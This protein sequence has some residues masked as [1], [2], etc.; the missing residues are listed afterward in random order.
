MKR[1]PPPGRRL[2]L[3]A[4]LLIAVFSIAPV[5]AQ[6]PS[7]DQAQSI[8]SEGAQARPASPG[9]PPEIADNVA[10]LTA[11]IETAEKTIQHLAELEEEL[12]GLRV[13]VETIIDDSSQIAEVL[14]PQLAAVRSQIDKLGPSPGKDGPAE[15]PALAAERARLTAFAAGLDGAIKSS[16]LTWVRARQLIEKIT[17][18]RH[19]LFAK[20]LME[21][22]PSPLL[23]DV[24]RDLM[25]KAP[26]VGNRISYLTDD[27]LRWAS[28]K[29]LKLGLL[30]SAVVILF[31]ALRVGLGRLTD[32]RQRPSEPPSFFERAMSVA[33]VAPL[34]ALPT[35]AAALLLYAG[36]DAMDLLFPPWGVTAAG[37]L[38]AVVLYAAV[39]AL[40]FA[41]LAPRTPQWRLFSLADGP[42]RRVGA[43]L[44]AITA[45]YA[46]DGALTEIS[47]V[48]F[49]P[50]ALTV[51][52]TF[53]TSIAFAALLIGLLLTPF[54]PQPTETAGAAEVAT[55]SASAAERYPRQAP[56]WLKLPLWLIALAILGLAL[57]GYVALARFVAQQLVLTGIVLVVSW[58]L[59]LAI[60][61]V[62]REPQQRRYPVGELLE[63]RFGLDAPRR[64]QLA[65]L[66]EIALTFAL[67][68]CAL[69]FLMMQW[70]FSGADIRDWFKS[71]FFGIEV[72]QFRISLARILIGIVLFIVLLF[73]TRLLQRWLREK[74]LQQTRMDPGIANSVDTV[75]GYVGVSLAALLAVSYAGV[76]ITNLAIVAGALSVGIGFGLQSIVNNFV[77]GLILLIERPIKVGDRI[78]VGDQQGLVRRISVR[79]TEIETFDR[80]SL[81]VPNSEL[82]TGRV[83]NWTHRDSLGAV[84]VKVGVGYDSD[85]EQVLAILKKCAD[86]HPDVLRTPAPMAFFDNFGDSALMFTLRIS[87]PDIAQAAR[88]QS[89][90][91]TAILK[92]LRAAEIEIP[93]NQLDVNLRQLDGVKRYHASHVQER[94]DNG[95]QPVEPETVGANNGKRLAGVAE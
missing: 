21:R 74:A 37:V 63:A 30:L 86:D 69:P 8:P 45:L 80:A 39:S 7:P 57:L 20:N 34:R 88:V 50:L 48:F 42:T 23:P 31:V 83:L 32:R 67:V 29:Q 61:A 13:D 91:R 94:A 28:I 4:A 87:L 84:N 18:L 85:P 9:L 26:P 82:I 1:T 71:L 35:I 65:R 41:M 27:W 54:I 90:L 16:E 77:S 79:A 60:R 93:F 33:W 12:G 70:G 78:V 73:A 43:L 14:R 25:S 17:V 5:A 15:A 62:T 72:G 64:N 66:T 56:R 10:R 11:A 58:L 52:Q 92:A 46:I 81:I 95:A 3:L 76:D 47:R 22:R 75:V 2:I 19:S 6:A 59:Y 38:K 36:L 49:V 51:V 24:W 40:I 55:S 44:C 89:D 68:I 53:A